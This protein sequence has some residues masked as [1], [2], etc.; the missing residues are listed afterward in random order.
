MKRYNSYNYWQSSVIQTTYM[1]NGLAEYVKLQ[2]QLVV[3]LEIVAI[4]V[5]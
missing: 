4:L 3:P 5:I 2:R 1:P